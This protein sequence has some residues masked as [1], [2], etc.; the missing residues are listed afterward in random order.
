VISGR[1][2]LAEAIRGAERLHLPIWVGLAGLIG[3]GAFLE[4]NLNSALTQT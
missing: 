2:T 4:P 1:S 3:S